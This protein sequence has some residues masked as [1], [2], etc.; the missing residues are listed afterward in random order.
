MKYLSFFL[1]LLLL[2]TF[3]GCD[4]YVEDVDEPIDS[5]DDTQLTIESQVP[6]LIKGVQSRFSTVYDQAA[7][8]AGGLSDELIFT[9]DVVNATFPT[10]R[11]M[12]DGDIE[13]A[14]NSNDALFDALGEL[15]LFSDNLLIRIEEITF[16]DADLR[17]EAEFNALFYGG[18]AR[19]FYATYYGLTQREGGGVI[20]EDSENLSPFIPSS[21][22]YLQA[23]DKLTAAQALAD[24]YYTRVINTVMARI[25][26]FQGNYAQARTA[27]EAGLVDGDAPFESL[28]S[29]D[30]TNYFYRIFNRRIVANARLAR[31]ER[32]RLVDRIPIDSCTRPRMPSRRDWVG[33]A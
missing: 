26:L 2:A 27:A 33:I 23:M 22:L 12:E 14:N 13:F 10:F 8:F 31:P 16:E 4:S 11:E 17:T 7:V 28:H 3:V 32:R 25:Q 9:E 5:I 19:Y 24:P 21:E 29:I 30:N 15:R 20:S 6:F 1:S 18:L